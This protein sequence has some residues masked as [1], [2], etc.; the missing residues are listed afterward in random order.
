MNFDRK[1]FGSDNHASVH[2][3]ILQALSDANINHAHSYGMDELTE[4]VEKTIRHFFTQQT[5]AFFVFNGT[6]ANILALKACTRSFQSVL[7]SDV[8]HIQVDECSGPEVHGGFKLVPIASTAGKLTL[9]KLKTQL[10]RR[11]DQHYPQVKTISITQPTELGT[12]YSAEEIKSIC[13]WAKT[14]DLYVH[15]DGS[16]FA[17]AS[18]FLKKSFAQLTSELGIDVLSFGGTKNGLM[19][20]ELVIFFNEQLAKDFQYL[21]KQLGQLPSKSRFLAAQFHAYFNDNLW[22]S[23]A[24]TSLNSAQLFAKELQ[25]HTTLKPEYSVESNAV[26]VK[27]PKNWI[28]EL[29]KERFFY[30]WDESTFICRIMFSWDSNNDEIHSFIKKI[31]QLEKGNTHYEV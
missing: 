3:K 13:D 24:Q 23:I 15:M 11:G 29:K 20:A 16:R 8:A 7:C 17:N 6:A 25:T 26:F 14:E 10:I 5:K 21:R 27:F 1:G 2:P 31:I 28:R 9:D 19:G 22:Q 18:V 12:C 30:V 4:N